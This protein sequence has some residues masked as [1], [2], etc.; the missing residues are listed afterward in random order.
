MKQVMIKGKIVK[1]FNR[2]K[3]DW[4]EMNEYMNKETMLAGE[5]L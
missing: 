3:L 2:D 1:P 4:Q 5:Y